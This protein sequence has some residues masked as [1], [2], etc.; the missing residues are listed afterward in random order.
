MWE[1]KALPLNAPHLL[2]GALC[3]VTKW[4]SDQVTKWPSDQVTDWPINRVTKRPSDWKVT[5]I[6][7]VIAPLILSTG[8]PWH[9]LLPNIAA[10]W[11]YRLPMENLTA[12]YNSQFCVSFNFL[13]FLPGSP[14]TH[15]NMSKLGLKIIVFISNVHAG[16]F[17]YRAGLVDTRWMLAKI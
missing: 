2:Y 13:F 16:F 11:R 8:L 3:M 15:L 4:P 12:H 10:R 14:E 9:R 1:F 7:I 6:S 5:G 17:L